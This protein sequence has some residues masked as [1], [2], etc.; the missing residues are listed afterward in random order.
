MK[1]IL[2]KL[3][4]KIRGKQIIHF[5]HIGKTG[6]TAVKYV[7]RQFPSTKNYAIYLHSHSTTFE[8]IPKGEKIIFFLRDPISKFVSGFYSRQRQGQPRI[9]KPWSQEEKVAF[10]YFPTAN[11]LAISLS[12]KDPEVKSHAEKAMRNI[13]HV[14]SS[15]WNWFHNEEYFKRRLD[16]IFFIGFQESLSE[17]FE[18]LKEKLGIPHQIQLP[19][20]DINTH[21]NPE[22]VDKS[23]EN[24]AIENLK[25]W[26]KEEYQFIILC[27]TIKEQ[28]KS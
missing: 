1:K 17:D 3:F 10:E 8:D 19:N 27:K 25:K 26:Y 16:D 15:Y 4:Y 21:K 7:F 18:I 12:S 11:Q 28:T 6:G 22:K 14:Q 20:D 13:K 9:F 24:E 5:I 2:K 23:L